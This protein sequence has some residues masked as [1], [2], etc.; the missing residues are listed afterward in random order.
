MFSSCHRSL[1]FIVFVTV[2][3]IKVFSFPHELRNDLICPSE[4]FCKC[5]IGTYYEVACPNRIDTSITIRVEPQQRTNRV[6]IECNSVDSEIFHHLPEWNIGASDVVKFN[7]CPLASNASIQQIFERLGI[8]N[9]SNLIFYA[10]S[11]STSTENDVNILSQHLFDN[12]SNVRSLDLRLN[13]MH[14]PSHILHSLHELEFLQISSTDLKNSIDG[15]FQHLINLKRLNLW[16]NNLRNLTKESFFG[17]PSVTD[18]EISS[19]DIGSLPS[20]AFEHLSSIESINLNSNRLDALPNQLFHANKALQKVKISSNYLKSN[21]LPNQ[22]LA[23]LPQLDAVWINDCN[24][25]HLPDD[26]FSGSFRLRNISLAYNNL[27]DIPAAI[28]QH[29]TDLTSLDLS[30]NDLMS[31]DN[32]IFSETKHL[33]ILHLSFNHLSNISR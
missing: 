28:F 30:H 12:V 10:K 18:L 11:I 9:V 26:L 31:L 16:S 19:N 17:I 25:T 32:N 21:M 2:S 22:F 1:F 33:F 24:F 15:L 6:E 29:Q 13:N 3:N 14:L 4:T 20:N 23:H 8:R 7:G 27:K 5:S